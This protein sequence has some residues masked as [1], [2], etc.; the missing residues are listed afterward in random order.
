MDFFLGSA[1][2]KLRTI[3]AHVQSESKHCILFVKFVMNIGDD[4]LLILSDYVDA[5]PINFVTYGLFM[6]SY[7]SSG[8]DRTYIIRLYWT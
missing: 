3:S 5:G 6:F 1:F 4:I 7:V 2:A 8:A